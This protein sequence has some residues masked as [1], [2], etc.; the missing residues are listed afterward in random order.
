MYAWMHKV[1]IHNRYRTELCEL[2]V[3]N[4]TV[5]C[6]VVSYLIHKTTLDWSV[7]WFW[8]KRSIFTWH[9]QIFHFYKTYLH[10]RGKLFFDCKFWLLLEDLIMCGLFS[11]GRDR[12]WTLKSKAWELIMAINSLVMSLMTNNHGMCWLLHTEIKI[13]VKT[14]LIMD[15]KTKCYCFQ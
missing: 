5:Y 14:I 4:K 10:R 2:S 13:K 9:A 15:N 12:G 7:S 6:I 8:F 11:V 1:K 3:D